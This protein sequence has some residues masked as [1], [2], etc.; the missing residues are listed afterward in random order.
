[1]PAILRNI[2]AVIAGSIVGGLVNATL[3]TIGPMIIPTPDGLDQTTLEGIQASIHLLQPKHFI[4]PFI[5]HALGTLVGA[6]V[7]VKIGVSHHLLLALAVG[8]LFLMGGLSMMFMVDGPA[9]FEYL[10]VL[11][12]YLPMAWIGAKLG[13]A[14]RPTA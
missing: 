5:A 13:G 14:K 6:L 3:V 1:M 9:W 8:L 4:F 11:V 7:A 2:L 12:A 10:D